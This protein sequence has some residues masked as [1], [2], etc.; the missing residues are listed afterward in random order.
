M[1]SLTTQSRGSD[2]PGFHLIFSSN[3]PGCLVNLPGYLQDNTGRQVLDANNN[4]IIAP[5]R[6]LRLKI[7]N[8]GYTVAQGVNVYVTKLSFWHQTTGT[9]E[10]DEE[11]MDLPVARYARPTFDLPPGGHRYMDVFS[12]WEH[13]G[14]H[15][16]RFAF[17]MPPDRIYLRPY[18][19]G[20]Y[21]A[22]LTATSHNAS[23]KHLPI[24]WH[25]DQRQGAT[26]PTDQ[27]TRRK[28]DRRDESHFGR[29]LH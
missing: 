12:A 9:E 28:N 29:Q 4:P 11:V 16:F 23:A 7:E 26:I 2:S 17:A 6:Y 1:H 13:D 21:R 22:A 19:F 3:V 10:F 5:L 25:W 27:R 20:S 24:D 14:H 18:S 15:E 8:R